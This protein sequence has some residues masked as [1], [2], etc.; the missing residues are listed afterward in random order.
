MISFKQGVDCTNIST[1]VFE[2]ILVAH[3]VYAD[4]NV[5]EIVITSL[6]DGEHMVGSKHYSGEAFDLRIWAF[7]EIQVVAVVADLVC[8]LG[9]DYDVVQHS[10][11]IH[12]EYDPV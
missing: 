11:H 7:S 10:S 6:C 9:D 2:G 8:A 3:D 1:K 12:I 5:N 4:A